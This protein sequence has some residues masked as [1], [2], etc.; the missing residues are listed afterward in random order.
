MNNYKC[1]LCFICLY[2]ALIYLVVLSEFFLL[3]FQA[4]LVYNRKI[5]ECSLLNILII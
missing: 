2:L 3:I 4:L 5:V 1:N